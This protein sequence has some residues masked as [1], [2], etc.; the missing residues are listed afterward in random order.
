LQE[1]KRVLK[2]NGY[3]LLQTLNKITN[4]FF[5]I[6][7]EKSFTKYKKYHC[8]LHTYRQIKKRFIK[9][10]FRVEF[11]NIPIVNNYFK[12]KIKKYLGF[13]GIFLIKFINIDK[14][15]LYLKTNF[16]I[17]AKKV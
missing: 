8:S 9:N 7:K 15:P 17:V 6:I 4:V 1:V 3:Y 16:Y 12:T 11:I 2:N 13:F 14:L 10:N 5:E